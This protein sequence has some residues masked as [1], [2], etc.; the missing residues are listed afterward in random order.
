M[1]RAEARGALQSSAYNGKGSSH[2]ASA[3]LRFAL[4]SCVP[5]ETKGEDY[6]AYQSRVVGH[7]MLMYGNPVRS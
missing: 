1:K 2:P 6:D 7:L 5:V 3:R 4:K